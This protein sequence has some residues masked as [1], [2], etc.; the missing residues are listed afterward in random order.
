MNYSKIVFKAFIAI[1]LIMPAGILA[2]EKPS[3]IDCNGKEVTL[4]QAQ[5]EVFEQ[6]EIVREF[7][8]L[9][10]K[11]DCISF[12]GAQSEMLKAENIIALLDVLSTQSFGV[13]DFSIGNMLK[14]RGAE[15]A[16]ELFK[17]ADYLVVPK[18]QLAQMADHMYGSIKNVKSACEQECVQSLK[19]EKLAELDLLQTTVE[20]HL[21]YCI[22][23]A[24]CVRRIKNDPDKDALEGLIKDQSLLY[25]GNHLMLTLNGIEKVVRIIPETKGIKVLNL[26]GN[27]L[28]TIDVTTLR[29]AFPKL[30]HISIRNNNFNTITSDVADRKL[31]KLLADGNNI[32]SIC[33]DNPSQFNKLIITAKNNPVALDNVIFKQSTLQKMLT[34]LKAFGAQGKI[35]CFDVHKTVLLVCTALAFVSGFGT[36]AYYSFELK[37][38]KKGFKQFLPLFLEKFKQNIKDD[39]YIITIILAGE[40]YLMERCACCW[41]GYIKNQLQKAAE[42]NPYAVCVETDSGN[43]EFPSSYAYKLF[44][45]N[46]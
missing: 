13:K 29:E 42:A 38:L 9:N 14:M 19:K 34:W 8:R 36:I 12:E 1:L 23:G 20:P 2:M 41:V 28:S 4:N 6:C 17:L 21:S 40:S 45:K 31:I 44:G 22:D 3:F 35:A 15:K 27:Q 43:K 37:D 7:K 18:N 24:E 46:N 10:P 30:E 33:L 26:F 5:Q 32:H 16:I 11:A 25:L 39:L